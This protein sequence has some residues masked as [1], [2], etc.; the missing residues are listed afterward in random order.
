MVIL[1]TR[2][3]ALHLLMLRGTDAEGHVCLINQALSQWAQHK[4]HWT[5]LSMSKIPPTQAHIS[6]RTVS[7]NIL[8]SPNVTHISTEIS[9]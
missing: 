1:I 3:I 5:Y 2:D 7:E 8:Y 6:P 4:T 9:P